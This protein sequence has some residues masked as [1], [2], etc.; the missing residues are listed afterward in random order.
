M[1]RNLW[2][3]SSRET[4]TEQDGQYITGGDGVKV[5][6]GNQ[7][8]KT[9]RNQEIKARHQSCLRSADRGDQK[10]GRR[11]KIARPTS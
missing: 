5:R 2:L 10:E 1:K 11:E 6:V 7:G 9:G 8:I 4:E 3:T